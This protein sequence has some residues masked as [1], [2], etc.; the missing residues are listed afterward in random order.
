MTREG[1]AGGVARGTRECGDR[2]VQKIDSSVLA[3]GQFLLLRRTASRRICRLQLV[4]ELRA[5]EVQWLN[6]AR[7]TGGSY[8]K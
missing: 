8:A 4:I 3:S 1:A 2:H 6:A 5:G 7:R